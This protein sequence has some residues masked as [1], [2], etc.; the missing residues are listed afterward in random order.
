MTTLRNLAILAAI[1][2]LSGCAPDGS[3]IDGPGYQAVCKS[4]PLGFWWGL[5]HGTIAP[6]A[7]LFSLFRADVGVYE[8]CNNGGWYDFGYMLGI[9][10]ILGGSSSSRD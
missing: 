6:F 10:A 2:L 3:L 8:Y 1:L 9:G 4:D 7:W 5:W